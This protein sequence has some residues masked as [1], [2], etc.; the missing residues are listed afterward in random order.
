MRWL[1]MSLGPRIQGGR[2]KTYVQAPPQ[3]DSTMPLAPSLWALRVGALADRKINFA[4][5]ELISRNVV[6]RQP[7]WLTSYSVAEHYLEDETV[8][9]Y[10]YGMWVVFDFEQTE[11]EGVLGFPAFVNWGLFVDRPGSGRTKPRLLPPNIVTGKI[12]EHVWKDIQVS[13]DRGGTQIQ[14]L[15]YYMFVGLNIGPEDEDIRNP[16]N[17]DEEDRNEM[18][19]PI[20]FTVGEFDAGQASLDRLTF[21]GVAHQPR[22]AALWPR[23]F[24]GE[25][26][27]TRH[28]A[29]AQAQVFNNHSWDLW[30]QMWH[31]QLMP[32]ADLEGWVA[33]FEEPGDGAPSMPWLDAE[34]V[35][36]VTDYLKAVAPMGESLLEH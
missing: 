19:G 20:N 31:A 7:Q 10:G 5:P 3:L 27:D 30:S 24:D 26:P 15:R 35:E 2:S 1:G 18:P 34:R 25:R 13:R 17:F 8:Q 29:L 4:Y 21:L 16:N 11:V 32:V 6:L 14:T 28:V 9:D 12:A 36:G 33:E 22:E 23:M